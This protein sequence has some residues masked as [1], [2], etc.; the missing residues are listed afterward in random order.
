[1]LVLQHKIQEVDDYFQTYLQISLSGLTVMLTILFSSLFFE[2]SLLFMVSHQLLLNHYTSQSC[3]ITVWVIV[4]LVT[5]WVTVLVT[6]TGYCLVTVW[7]QFGYSLVTVWLQLQVTDTSNET[8]I[9]EFIL[10][11][12][13]HLRLKFD[14]AF[15]LFVRKIFERIQ[16]GLLGTKVSRER[17]RTNTIQDTRLFS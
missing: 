4:F 16:I 15:W 13:G 17:L 12:F 9:T 7:L 8:I 14:F 5:V 6:V 11:L 2:D 10:R 1:M 3:R